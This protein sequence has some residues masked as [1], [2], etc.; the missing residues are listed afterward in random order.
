VVAIARSFTHFFAH[1]S[2]GFCTPCRVGTSLLGQLIDKI[3]E[4]HGTPHD[5]IEM[6]E[7]AAIVKST[8]HCGLG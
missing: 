7:L 6:T 4:G 2:C 8:S 5:L 3:A 1:E